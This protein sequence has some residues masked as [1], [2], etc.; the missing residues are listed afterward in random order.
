VAD[1][2]TADYTFINEA[3]AK[4]YGL[5]GVI[6]N[7][8]RRVKVSDPNRLGLLGHG[9]LLTLT[10]LTTRTS[11]VIRG[12]YVLEVLL[13]TPPPPPPPMVPDLKD[14][15]INEKPLSVRERIEQHRANAACASCHRLMD[16]IGLAL[17]NFNAV[18]AWRRTDGGIPI[19]AS[20]R[21]FDGAPLDGPASLRNAILNRR[22][23]FYD[24]FTEKLLAYGLGRVVD[25]RDMPTVR[26]IRRN[27]AQHGN[28][29][30]AYVLGVVQS[31][32]FV[33]REPDAAE[34]IPRR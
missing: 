11:P 19:D 33:M 6:G 28:R 18:G 22:D 17:E 12:Q 7:Q 32:P 24:N 8:F 16:P 21:M 25:Y 3:L 1:L 2:L 23:S 29:F 4:H 10:S 34:Y 9:S 20:S 5:P 30:S 15:V 31:T 27:A 26:S 13:G 14:N